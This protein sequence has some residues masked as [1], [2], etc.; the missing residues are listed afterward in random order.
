MGWATEAQDQYIQQEGTMKRTGPKRKS[1]A[2]LPVV[3][4]LAMAFGVAA[5]AHAKD[6]P[7]ISPEC[8]AERCAAQAAIDAACPCDSAKNHGKYVSCVAKTAKALIS[9][10]CKG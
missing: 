10:K 6:H 5:S 7:Q 9:K 2:W 3:G 1:A 8:Q 4:G